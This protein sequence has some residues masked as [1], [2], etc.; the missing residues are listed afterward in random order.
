MFF[1]LNSC[2]DDD[3]IIMDSMEQ[4]SVNGL[5]SK[6][7]GNVYEVN[8]KGDLIKN[9]DKEKSFLILLSEDNNQISYNVQDDIVVLTNLNTSEYIEIT[10]I[11][12]NDN[13]ITFD[14]QTS[15][16]VSLN[17]LSFLN[18]YGSNDR[19]WIPIVGYVVKKAFELLD[20]SSLEEC[21][22]GMGELNCAP[23]SSPYM[24]FKETWFSTTCNVGCMS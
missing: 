18:N 10:K 11:N 13:F 4:S 1:S 15:S 3:S 14:A 21:T 22:D 9:I 23:G 8:E 2:Y 12:Q 6:G 7:I 5:Y 16:G 19:F 20:A 24:E 17:G